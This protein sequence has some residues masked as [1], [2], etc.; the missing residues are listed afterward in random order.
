MNGVYKRGRSWSIGGS[1]CLAGMGD[2]PEG[3]PFLLRAW[4]GG[5]EYGGYGGVGSLIAALDFWT[6]RGDSELLLLEL[7]EACL[8]LL[9]LFVDRPSTDLGIMTPI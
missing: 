6:A 4:L 9:E 7:M 2:S 1:A 5:G 3:M 8:E